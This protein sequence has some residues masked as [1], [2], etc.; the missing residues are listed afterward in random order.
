M[1]IARSK[2]TL[3][4]SGGAISINCNYLDQCEN[5][6]KN[7]RFEN[8]TAQSK[9]GAIIYNSYVPTLVNNTY[10]GNKALYSKDV[11]SYPVKVKK[12]VNDTH[13]EDI[14]V[15]NDIP[16][17]IKIDDPINLAIVNVGEDQIVS[18]DSKSNI[19]LVVIE[20]DTN[21]QGQNIVTLKHGKATFTNTVFY[22][23]PG[24]TNVK[25]RIESSAINKKMTQY[26]DASKYADQIISINF[27]WCK[28]GEIQIGN[29]CSPCNAGSYSVK[30]N[31]TRWETWP[32]YT[33]WEGEKI[34][35]N[36][37]YW[38]V[39][40]NSTTIIECPNPD[41]CLGGYNS[42]SEYPVNW[43]DGYKGILCNE[44]VVEDDTKYERISE[45]QCSKCPN[46]AA[47]L[48]RII[49]CGIGILIFMAILIA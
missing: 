3:A 34:S 46:S 9:G 27:R 10:E 23:S 6:I 5:I 42:T 8:N 44:W 32:D 17:G 13:L 12:L 31:G 21:V 18:N 4:T 36:Q 33:A 37:G 14:L 43:E 7:S 29:S 22:A 49:G 11:E 48:M 30:W 16:S 39:S 41:A 24:K 15:L 20:K 47:N 38:R 28:P 35:L 26:L 2:T 19:K 25:F 1:I 45:N 40:R